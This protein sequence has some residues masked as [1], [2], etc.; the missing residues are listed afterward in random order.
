MN[1]TRND[2]AGDDPFARLSYRRLIAWPA[3]M[4]RETPFLEAALAAAPDRSA[5]D[6]G[7]GPGEHARLLASWGVRTLGIDRSESMIEQAREHEGEFGAAG[8]RFVL[9]PIESLAVADDDRFGAAFSLGN[10]L[11]Y[12]EDDELPR[13]L[14]AVAAALL[15]GGVFAGQLL[16]Y[17]PILA[18]EVRS[19]P[20]NVRPDP[21]DDAAEI[22]FL[23]PLKPD[24]DGR[25]ALFFPTTLHLVPGADPPVRIERT[26]EVRVRAWTWPELDA[27]LEAAGFDERRAYGDVE[28][29]E[30]AP[31]ASSDLVFT[32]RR[33]PR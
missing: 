22:L 23:R 24:G 11:P 4:R 2:P 12:L 29:A 15:P 30:F 6:L 27:A 20:L 33:A 8:P 13:A 1:E 19:L 9:G 16:N 14:A 10:V 7:C 31:D 18:G 17:G 32:A 28:R 26:K 21:A 5:V 3:R 25:H